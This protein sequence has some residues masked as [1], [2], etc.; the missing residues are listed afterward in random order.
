MQYGNDDQQHERYP[1]ATHLVQPRPPDQPR[2]ASNDDA[3][4]YYVQNLS[5]AVSEPSYYQLHSCE[6]C[7]I[8][9]VAIVLVVFWTFMFA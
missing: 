6:I 3:R 5:R 7:A 4:Q 1:L 2:Q 8:A 9:T